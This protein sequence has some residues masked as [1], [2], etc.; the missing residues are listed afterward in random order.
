MKA[1]F[2][3]VREYEP[4]FLPL[5]PTSLLGKLRRPDTRERRKSSLGNTR[6]TES[7]LV[8]YLHLMVCEGGASFLD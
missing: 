4:A 2:A 3:A 6:V 1:A 7:Q 8:S 5:E